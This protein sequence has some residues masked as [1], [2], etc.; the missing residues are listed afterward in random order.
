[1]KKPLLNILNL[2][3]ILISFSCSGQ[4][5]ILYHE[6]VPS[7]SDFGISKWNINQNDLSA[8]YLTEKIDSKNRVIELKFYE[9][10]KNN[11]KHLCYLSTWIK[12]EYPNKRTIIQYN[13][14]PDGI[15]EANIECEL[16]SKIIYHLSEN[17]KIIIKTE[18]EYEFDKN[19]YLK[20][21]W[22]NEF[23]EELLN[24]LK[25]EQRTAF[26]IE[27]YLKSWTK[28]NGIFPVSTEFDLDHFYFNELEK[29]KVINGIK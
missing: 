24:G 13:L 29:E 11:F 18:S 6:F 7:A 3:F 23:I 20:I 19:Y 17:Q 1:M 28:L 8:Y 26:V 27:F 22:T 4:E 15:P 12:F 14:N 10:G 9:D 25:S 21:G 16:P 5:K 2:F